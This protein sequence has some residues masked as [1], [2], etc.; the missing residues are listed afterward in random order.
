MSEGSGRTIVGWPRLNVRSQFN[1]R[2]RFDGEIH[3]NLTVASS[4]LRDADA[5]LNAGKELA[6][7]R[8]TLEIAKAT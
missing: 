2:S 7:V 3:I 8:Q 1:V 6:I 5:M 4:K